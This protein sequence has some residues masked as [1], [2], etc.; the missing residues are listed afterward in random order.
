MRVRWLWRQ[1][2]PAAFVEDRAAIRAHRRLRQLLRRL[3]GIMDVFVD[4]PVAP[5]AGIGGGVLIHGALVVGENLL[6]P[7][8]DASQHLP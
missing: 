7:S 8:P 3:V 6:P 4:E 5:G 1:P 2:L